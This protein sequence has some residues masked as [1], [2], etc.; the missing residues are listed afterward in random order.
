MTG[1]TVNGSTR[2]IVAKSWIGGWLLS[3]CFTNRFMEFIIN[4]LACPTPFC[5][6]TWKNCSR[7]SRASGH[8]IQVIVTP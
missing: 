4:G 6:N 1:D 3:R 5:P 7:K 2:S 8:R